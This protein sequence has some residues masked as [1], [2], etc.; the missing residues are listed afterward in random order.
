[1]TSGLRKA[2]KYIWLLLLIIVPVLMFFS[3][4]DLNYSKPQNDTETSFEFGNYNILMTDE[5]NLLKA[6]AVK[7]EHAIELD[8]E[9]KTPFK[10]ASSEVYE[11]NENNKKGNYLGMITSAK[12][13]SFEL[14]TN[15]TGILI[16]DSLKKREITK[17][18]F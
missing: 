6:V 7:T 14:N 3:I 16:Y 8:F 5:N 15:A 12:T 9:I 18:I 11:L 4:K 10:S 17:L 13:Y 2:H 1:M